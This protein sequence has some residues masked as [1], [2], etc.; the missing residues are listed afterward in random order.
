MAM[1]LDAVA[2]KVIDELL[3]AVVEMKDRAVK[4][5]PT[6]ERLESTLKSIEPLAKQI[7]GL[8]KRLDRPAEETKKLI[9]QMERGKKLVL[10]CS[11]VQWWNCCHKAN[12]QE[13]LQDLDDSIVRFF[14]LDMQAQT[15]RNG[16]EI[17][18]EVRDIH[19]ELRNIAPRRTELRR[20]CSPPEPPAFTVGLDVHLMELKL[21]LLKD[22]HKGSVLTVT[23]TGGSGKSTLA[24][25]FCWDEDVKGKFKENIFFFPF[26]RTPKLIT[27]VERLF[28]HTGTQMPDLQSDDDAAN[29]LEHLLNQ[30]GE[31]PIL[32]VLDDVWP[33]SVSLVHKF[34]FQIPNY[35]ILMTSRVAIR[36]FDP[37]YV[38]K[39]LDEVN[40][41]NLFCDSASLNPS[42]SHIPENVVN[43]IVRG[44]SGFPLALTV[45]GG[46]LRHQQPL[47]W[48]N[49]ARKLSTGHSILDSSQYVLDCLQKSFD[50]LDA[51]VAEC[52]RDLGLFPEAQRIPAAALVDMWAELHD[53][54]DD[55]AME[56]IYKLVD[57]N[58]ADV[59]V[60]RYTKYFL[61]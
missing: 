40:A 47:V 50:V 44:C 58:L 7:D 9:D 48:K 60:T 3:S 32:L 2:G 49:M 56:N 10:K 11:K 35:V 5:K 12:Y 4:F 33:E 22:H 43:E 13:E 15:N 14:N 18:V 20:V 34:A 31:S 27:I 8:N 24:K 61:C 6:L 38:L 39:P 55:S 23:G 51:K 37:A 16:L 17:L 36:E 45:I 42:S 52:F 29:Q 59:V 19:A 41:M 28:Q 46:N 26:A 57:R 1:V 53:E 25:K 30:I 21:R 54:D